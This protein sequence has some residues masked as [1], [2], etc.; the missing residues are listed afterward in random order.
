MAQM[1]SVEDDNGVLIK[2]DQTNLSKFCGRE[3]DVHE[4]VVVN[5]LPT[6]QNYT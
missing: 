4:E 2:Q 3:D 1:E 6:L 5:I